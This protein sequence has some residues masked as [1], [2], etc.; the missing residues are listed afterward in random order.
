[1]KKRINLK[2]I[3]VP[4]L[5]NE[6]IEYGN[7]FSRGVKFRVYDT[8]FIFI[9]GTAS[10]DENGKTYYPNSFKKQVER[11]Y[12]NLTALLESENADWHDVIMTK[13]YLK[14][15]KYYKDFNKFRT[16]YYKEL[17]LN[18]FPAS[19]GI[20]ATL[21]RSDLLIEIELT[22]AYKFKKY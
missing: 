7:S 9:S 2:S 18:P 17:K 13:C 21:C 4:G 22:A 14:D 16:K 3:H 15:M 1:M 8:L 19:V 5:L 20:Q 10:I 12:K 11:V 6:A